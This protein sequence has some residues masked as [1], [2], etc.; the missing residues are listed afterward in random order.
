MDLVDLIEKRRFLGREFLLWL[1]FQGDLRENRFDVE[2]FGPC[3][4]QLEGQLTL[5]QEKEQSRLKGAIPSAAPEAREALRQGKLPT[6]A[7]MRI[8]RGELTFTFVLQSDSLALSGV[9][10]PA[11]VKE[12]EDERFYERMYLV[13]E[14]EAM[15]GALY[16]EFL[17]QR[18][19]T[20]WEQ[21]VAPAI[22]AWVRGETVDAAALTKL[23][24]KPL[25]RRPG[26][27]P[28]DKGD[29]PAAGR[30]S[31]PTT[32]APPALDGSGRGKAKAKAVA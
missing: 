22:R 26:Q 19:S 24:V 4:I 21:T 2:D 13:E 23:R 11:Q 5:T 1:W 14:L 31:R 28:S 7:R 15:L 8:E 3:D 29:A 9:R 20:S 16:S 12:E 30:A 6:Q 17:A 10:I 32:M 27:S 18:L 25:G